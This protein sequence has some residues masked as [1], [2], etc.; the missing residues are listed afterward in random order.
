M[1]CPMRLGPA[2]RMSTCA[3]ND[4]I[5]TQCPV[6][7]PALKSICVRLV[8][9]TSWSRACAKRLTAAH[10]K[11]S[12]QRRTGRQDAPVRH[13]TVVTKTFS[14]N[15]WNTH[16]ALGGGLALAGA[17]VAGV[18]VGGGRLELRSAGVHPLHARLHAQLLPP[19]PYFQR[20]RGCSS[21]YECFRR[22]ARQGCAQPLPPC[23]HLQRRR[24]CSR[25]WS[26]HVSDQVLE[27][28]RQALPQHLHG[29][30]LRRPVQVS[31][32]WSPTPAQQTERSQ[33]P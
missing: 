1:P 4:G 33:Q 26:E 14:E 13:S 8:H 6:E 22:Q 30:T 5:V 21:R 31:C 24:R 2:P 17:V 27:A 15:L 20:R 18:H 25:R 10:A 28:S 3:R 32:R 16:L 19:R 23:L 29:A 11:R 7:A 12:A 9:S